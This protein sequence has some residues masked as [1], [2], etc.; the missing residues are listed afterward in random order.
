MMGFEKLTLLQ[1]LLEI[2][3]SIEYIQKTEKGNQGAMYVDPAVLV[4]K[5]K[6][7]MDEQNILSCA[8]S[9]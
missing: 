2:R 5:I 3:K 9:K 8:K 6:D 1:K 7:K 4:K